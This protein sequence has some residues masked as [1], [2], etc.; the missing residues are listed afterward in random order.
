VLQRQG[1]TAADPKVDSE[2]FLDISAR[3]QGV[4]RE[5]YSSFRRPQDFK[6]APSQPTLTVADTQGKVVG[7]GNLEFG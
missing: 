1:T 7:S 3:I 5:T 6:P 2:F 4:G